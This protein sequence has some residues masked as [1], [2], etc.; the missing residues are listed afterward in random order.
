MPS[1]QSDWARLNFSR[2][3]MRPGPVELLPAQTQGGPYPIN[4]KTADSRPSVCQ[5][6]GLLTA[7][8]RS[9]SFLS[10][11]VSQ[12]DATT[13]PKLSP[14]QSPTTSS[15]SQILTSS[16]TPSPTVCQPGEGLKRALGEVL[17]WRKRTQG[18][19]AARAM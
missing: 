4:R 5:L 16:Q 15:S 10:S 1:I 19:R 14:T 8:E 13:L 7:G 18:S 9:A 17:S 6:A 11:K 2:P 12:N 3:V